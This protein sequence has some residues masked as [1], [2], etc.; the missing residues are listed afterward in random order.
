MKMTYPPCRVGQMKGSVFKP[1]CISRRVINDGPPLNVPGGKPRLQ[2]LTDAW[3]SAAHGSRLRPPRPADSGG[4]PTA[5]AARVPPNSLALPRPRQLSQSAP[6]ARCP[7]PA[8]P[9][10]TRGRPSRGRRGSGRVAGSPLGPRGR[11]GHG[12][13]AAVS[14]GRPLGALPPRRARARLGAGRPPQVPGGS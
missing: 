1:L 9:L 3:H 4:A 2:A 6:A 10:R 8:L 14:A 11:R 5:D 13:D 7:R 12:S